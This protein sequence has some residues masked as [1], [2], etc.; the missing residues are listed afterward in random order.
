MDEDAR[1][2][3]GVT[4]HAIWRALRDTRFT[5]GDVGAR[6]ELIFEQLQRSAP[7]ERD[8]ARQ[9]LDAAQVK[10]ARYERRVPT[11]NSLIDAGEREAE[12]NGVLAVRLAAE[13]D[14]ARALVGQLQGQLDAVRAL[15]PRHTWHGHRG[16]R[17]LWRFMNEPIAYTEQ[18]CPHC[19]VPWPCSTA[20]AAA[21]L[22]DREGTQ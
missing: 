19:R 8:A 14:A 3:D 4:P 11:L 16:R 21:V 22:S 2:V 17:W 15:H 13:R 6:A 7:A 1:T 12:S 9:Q 10:I 18:F 5:Q 20:L